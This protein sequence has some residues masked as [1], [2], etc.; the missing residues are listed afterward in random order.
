MVQLFN[1]HPDLISMEGIINN[2]LFVTPKRYL[3]DVTD[4][5][6]H[7]NSSTSP[8]SSSGCSRSVCTRYRRVTCLLG[9]GSCTNAPRVGLGTRVMCFMQ[10]SRVDWVRTLEMDKVQ[11]WV[12]VLKEWEDR[13]Q[14]EGGLDDGLGRGGRVMVI[15]ML[16]RLLARDI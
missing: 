15:R 9:R 5:S 6:H 16:V 13:G 3:L 10:T 14:G 11:K 4:T 1:W 2:L 12:D 8:A 7:T